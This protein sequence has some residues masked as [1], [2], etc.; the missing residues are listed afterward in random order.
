MET[1]EDER[2]PCGQMGRRLDNCE[3]R[4]HAAEVSRHITWCVADEAKIARRSAIKWL[5]GWFMG[6]VRRRVFVSYFVPYELPSGCKA[7]SHMRKC[8]KWISSNGLCGV[9]NE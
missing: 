9:P 5:D 6:G 2:K 1:L 8:A 7:P 3:D 4:G